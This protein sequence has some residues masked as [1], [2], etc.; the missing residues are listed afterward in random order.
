VCTSAVTDRRPCNIG[1]ARIL[2]VPG[3]KFENQCRSGNAKLVHCF[4]VG[5]WLRVRNNSSSVEVEQSWNCV[6]DVIGKATA[7]TVEERVYP[8]RK[9]NRIYHPKDEADYPKSR[10]KNFKEELKNPYRRAGFTLSQLGLWDQDVIN[11][12]VGFDSHRPL[13]A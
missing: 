10:S 12:S 5:F 1:K 13:I 9:Q 4:V 6:P 8:P 11:R 7:N 3:T 2:M